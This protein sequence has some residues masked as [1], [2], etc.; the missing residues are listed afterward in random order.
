V[1][2]A[3]ALRLAAERL[4]EAG[5]DT[6]DVDAELLL[7]HLLGTTRSGVHAAQDR[8]VPEGFD[9]LLERRLRREPLAYV[10][11]EWGFRRL[12]LKTDAR[13][14]VP[15][16]ETE[17]LVERA[18]ALLRGEPEPRVLDLGTGT[19]AIA[20]AIADEHPGARITAVDS[21]PQALSLARENAEALGL[22]VEVRLGGIETVSEGWDL[23]VAN[24]PYVTPAEWDTLQPEIHDWEPRAALVGEG[25]HEEIARRADTRWLALEV[26]DG[27]AR[28]VADALRSLRYADVTITRDLAGKERVVEGTATSWL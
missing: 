6:P 26:G 1:T 18:L 11:G 24:P 14:L 5:V 17:V 23:V 10:L 25:L 19:G 27:Q 15:R 13:A 3:A 28:R 9:E 12:L 2:V 7:A 4:A 8:E 16:P 22:A 21:S 20:L